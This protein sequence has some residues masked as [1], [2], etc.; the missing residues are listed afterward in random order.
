MKVPLRTTLPAILAASLFAASGPAS[1]CCESLLSCAAAIATGGLSCAVEALLNSV[2]RMKQD[3]DDLRAKIDADE[4]R[5][6]GAQL[7]AIHEVKVALVRADQVLK[8]G[9][10]A[11]DREA[12]KIK[13][14]VEARSRP[15]AHLAT[16]GAAGVGA[17][18]SIALAPSPTPKGGS[19]SSIAPPALGG[20]G[21]RPGATARFDPPCDDSTALA[22]LRRALEQLKKEK[23]ALVGELEKLAAAAA[24]AEF[25][26]AEAATKAKAVADLALLAPLAALSGTL[27]DL[28]H[29]PEHLFNPAAMVEASVRSVTEKIG[30]ELD[31]MTASIERGAEPSLEEG[32]R[33]AQNAERIEAAAARVL[34]AMADLE[35]SQTKANCDRLAAL[36]PPPAGSLVA[37]LAAVEPAALQTNSRTATNALLR[38]RPG[39]LKAGQATLEA[40]SKLT[41]STRAFVG[42][43]QI[44]LK[45]TPVPG[46]DG[47]F[48]SHMDTQFRGLSKS[49]GTAKKNELLADVRRVYANDPKTLG[50]TVDFLTRES[51]ARIRALR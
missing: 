31:K 35:K 43:Q 3:V 19:R 18:G 13:E 21:T 29:H 45:P 51:D 33:R 9:F 22:N 36:L 47:S 8:E 46:A 27:D 14:R 50:R 15:P 44:A 34:K 40:A 5:M 24:G 10:E 26:A 6:V 25:A 39:N 37:H 17:G 7:A 48:K 11:L 41:A 12:E 1:A 30:S 32:R 49:Q 4:K 2:K 16:G 20:A 23:A 28:I 38:A 42:T